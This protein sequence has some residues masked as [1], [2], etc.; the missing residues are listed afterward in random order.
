MP[1]YEYRCQCGNRF[2]KLA[3]R[4]LS[5]GQDKQD[6]PKCAKPA[7]RALSVCNAASDTKQQQEV[8][9]PTCGTCGLPGGPCV[10]N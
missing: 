2:E 6:C 9:P 3:R 10:M 7:P 4:M 8:A 1:V 5:A